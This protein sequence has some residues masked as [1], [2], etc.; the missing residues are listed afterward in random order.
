M[1]VHGALLS[2]RGHFLSLALYEGIYPLQECTL[3]ALFASVTILL[4][5]A[6]S[7]Q[8]SRH[9]LHITAIE[10]QFVSNLLIRY[11][12]SPEVQTQYPHFQRLM[13]SRKN[14]VGQIIKASVTAVTLVALTGGFRV[15]KAALD[16]VF[17]LAR[18]AGDTIW[19]A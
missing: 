4:H 5:G 10:R 3:A 11:I 9:L 2:A 6:K 8:L 12:Q 18:G 17:G 16:D 1:L 14:G 13:M 19:P 7:W 15:I